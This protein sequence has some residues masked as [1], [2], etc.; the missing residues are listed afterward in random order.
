MKMC[1]NTCVGARVCVCQSEVVLRLWSVKEM[2]RASCSNGPHSKSSELQRGTA[3][4][5][6]GFELCLCAEQLPGKRDGG[7]P[8]APSVFS[9]VERKLEEVE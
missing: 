4:K 6:A 9:E 8:Q 3:P 2:Q 1:I 7:I 5:A